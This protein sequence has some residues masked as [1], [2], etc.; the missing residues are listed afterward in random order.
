MASFIVL[1]PG[2]R[3]DELVDDRTV[4][5]RDG[6]ALLAFILPIPWLLVQRLWFEAVLVLAATIALSAV[7]SATGHGDMAA[8][9]TALLSLLVGLEGNNWRAAKFE[10]KGFEQSA[11]VTADNAIDAETIYFYG[12]DFAAAPLPAPRATVDTSLP[13]TGSKPVSGGM[14]GLVSHRGEN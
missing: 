9:V 10:R 7:G 8:V 12:N 4:F 2:L 1:T 14:L 11:V 5:V 6:F 13:E 3:N